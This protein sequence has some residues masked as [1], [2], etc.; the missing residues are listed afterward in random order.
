V[1]KVR[2]DL[3]DELNERSLVNC[4]VLTGLMRVC[5]HN[6]LATAALV[7]ARVLQAVVELNNVTGTIGRQRCFQNK[8]IWMR[9]LPVQIQSTNRA[10]HGACMACNGSFKYRACT[11]VQWLVGQW[12][13]FVVIESYGGKGQTGKEVTFG[14]RVCDKPESNHK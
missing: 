6:A 1:H 10:G 13:R 14:P 8:G 11:A 7:S 9:A 3:S 4:L 5:H 12:M 2:P